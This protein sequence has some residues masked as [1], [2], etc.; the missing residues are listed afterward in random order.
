MADSRCRRNHN[1]GNIRY[2]EFA[3]HHGAVGT[4][5]VF[6]IFPTDDAGFRA[7]SVLLSA[8]YRGLTVAQAIAKWAP[9]TENNTA[10]YINDVVEWTNL[11]PDTELT[12]D[13]LRPPAME[14][15]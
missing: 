4:D 14:T 5:G 11:K 10:Q 9:P 12:V 13:L 3:Q 8:A 7:M 6:A 2:G 1:P 15:A